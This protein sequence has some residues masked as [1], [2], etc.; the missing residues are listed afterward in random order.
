LVDLLAGGDGLFFL[1]RH[2][3]GRL[4]IGDNSL[5]VARD[6]T[7]E[8]AVLKFAGDELTNCFVFV[9]DGKFSVVYKV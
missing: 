2:V 6:E 1:V 5:A 4:L 9:E 3:D 8:L 7:V